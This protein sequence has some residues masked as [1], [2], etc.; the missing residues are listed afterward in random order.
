[1]R[2]L[3]TSREPLRA[4]GE[5]IYRVSPLDTPPGDVVDVDA[6]LGYGAVRL[7]VQRVQAIDARFLLTDETAT[8]VAMICRRLDGIPLAIELA[9]GRVETLGV[10][11]VAKRL[12]DRFRLLTGGRRT[13][14]DRHQ[15]LRATLDWSYL[16]LDEPERTLLGRVGIFVNGFTLAAAASLFVGENEQEVPVAD[17]L[18][19]LTS[20]SL[21][22]ADV[23]GAIPR[24][25]L[26]ET[27][28]AYALEKLADGGKSAFAAARHAR[29]LALYNLM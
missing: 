25:H 7:F 23:Q 1:L 16:L 17:L 2:M 24:Y 13:A 3:V 14:L 12:G 6:L 20:K 27:M 22:V 28:Q 19:S 21:V 26:L 10:A 18:A 8:T 5:Y 9:A 11:E 4:D 15:T 29:L